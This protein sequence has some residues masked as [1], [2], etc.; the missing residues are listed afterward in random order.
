M[1]TLDLE[2]YNDNNSDYSYFGLLLYKNCF[3]LKT[4]LIL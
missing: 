3:F 1:M 2:V 4:K